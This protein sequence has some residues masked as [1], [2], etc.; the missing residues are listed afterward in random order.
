M[1]SWRLGPRD[2]ATAHDFMTDLSERLAGR[3]LLTTDGHRVY[4]EAVENA[5]GM[6]VDYAMLR[7][8]YGLTWKPLKRATAPRSALAAK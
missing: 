6:D 3:I 7:K 5:F 8:I 1:I 2:L 4:V